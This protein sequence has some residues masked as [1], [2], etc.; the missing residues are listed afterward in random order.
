ME[1]AV[2]STFVEAARSPILPWKPMLTA[3]SIDA[4]AWRLTVEIVGD[5]GAGEVNVVLRRR[6]TT[7]DWNLPVDEADGAV[8]LRLGLDDGGPSSAGRPLPAGH[9]DVQVSVAGSDGVRQQRLEV[10]VGA[11]GELAEAYVEL[12][13]LVLTPY[14]TAAGGLALLVGR[15]R[16]RPEHQ[17]RLDTVRTIAVRDRANGTVRVRLDLQQ[18][19]AGATGIELRLENGIRTVKAAAGVDATGVL[20]AIVP[21]SKV[22]G[23]TWV[24]S[25]R[26]PGYDA[27]LGVGGSLF[28]V[29]DAPVA[30]LYGPPA[31][32]TRVP[33][34]AW[35]RTGRARR[36]AADV[37]DRLASTSKTVLGR[38]PKP[39][40]RRVR[41]VLL[42]LA[43]AAGLR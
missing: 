10:P 42:R 38:L 21:E 23:G 25:L 22:T 5:A 14:M 28:V 16:A 7:T 33:V 29:R 19:S 24:I 4:A 41:P 13:A 2:T 18:L 36:S 27:W 35:E 43:R 3:M 39:V 17:L 34:H 31:T 15:E 8:E 26:Y 1:H 9:Y 37:T 20:E 40:A 32:V 11:L 12:G 30:V 6:G